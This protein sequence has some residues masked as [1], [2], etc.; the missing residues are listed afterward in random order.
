[1]ILQFNLKTAFVV[2]VLNFSAFFSVSQSLVPGFDKEE[3]RQLMLIS[4]RTGGDSTYTSQFPE[5]EKF[6]MIYRS[7]I[8]GLDNLWDLWVD[9]SS[10]NAVISVRGTT[11]NATSWMANFYAAMVPAK[12]TLKLSESES[13]DYH[14]AE[15][16]KAAVHVGWLLSTA[17]LSK[18]I[19]P[20]IDSLYKTGTTNILIMG[21]S[22]GGAIA[23][24]L[25]AHLRNLQKSKGLPQEIQ[26]KT[27][28]SAGPK[29]GNLFF[30]YEYEAMTQN[31]WAFNVVNSADWVPETPFSVQTLDDFNKTNPFV[32]A[33]SMI[34]KM[35]FPQNIALKSVYKKLDKPS[36]KAQKNYEKYLGNMTSKIIT[37]SLPEFEPPSY[38]KSNDYVRTGTTIVL[39]AT[40]EYYKEFPDDEEKIFIHHFH[41]PY[42]YL[43][44]KLELN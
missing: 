9:E 2:I 10:K 35:K 6:K 8:V 20:K 27:Y 13:F 14:L 17:Y 3:Y 24:L 16:D 29:P 5:P 37:K 12:G 4:A 38:F 22:Q 15:N 33:K 30:A 7:E 36:R 41:K 11:A 19:L 32:N 18:D 40:P 43:L 31:G 26:F 21:H 44:E 23:F 1:M 34:K 42:L 28:C 25:T 39:F